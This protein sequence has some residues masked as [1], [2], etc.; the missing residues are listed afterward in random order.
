MALE[1]T[2]TEL[3]EEEL[4][5]ALLEG[6]L[7]LRDLARRYGV[8]R[9]WIRQLAQK[10]AGIKSAP[11]ERKPSWYAQRMGRPELASKEWLCQELV[12]AGSVKGLARKL[13]IGLDTLKTQLA[14]L[15]IDYRQLLADSSLSW[16]EVS[17]RWCGKKIRRPTRNFTVRKYRYSFCNRYCLGKW[18]GTTSGFKPRVSEADRRFIKHHWQEMTDEEMAEVLGLKKRTLAKTRRA[19]GLLRQQ[20]ARWQRE[21]LEFLQ[22]IIPGL[23]KK[24]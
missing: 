2:L 12:K 9:E 17:C 3:S 7:T 5:W 11:K 18:L 8:S 14:R 4:R 10:K 15:N 23:P 1:S 6:G 22:K 20:P 16:V 24:K 19:L 13:G 21:E